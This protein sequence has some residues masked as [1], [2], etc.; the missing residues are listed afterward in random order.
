[1]SIP[2]FSESIEIAHNLEFM[3]SKLKSYLKT[4][5]HD[6]NIAKHEFNFNEDDQDIIQI[7]NDINE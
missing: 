1:M 5:N 4:L 3:N 7:D 6:Y 2:Y